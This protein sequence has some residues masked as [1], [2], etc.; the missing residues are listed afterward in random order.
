MQ[1]RAKKLCPLM[2]LKLPTSRPQPQENFRLQAS[3]MCSELQKVL[4]RGS[5]DP[6]PHCPAWS[7]PALLAAGIVFLLIQHSLTIAADWPQLLGPNANGISSETGLVSKWG[8]NGPPIVWQKK[9]GTGYGAPSVRN[10][11]VVLHHRVEG[12]EIVEAFTV[13]DG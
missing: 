12:Q 10:N 3:R 13:E 8:T 9:I 4:G 2:G 7:R 1:D 6:K 5:E 11:M